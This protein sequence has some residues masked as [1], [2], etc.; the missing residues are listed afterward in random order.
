MCTW[1]APSRAFSSIRI[2]CM[3]HSVIGAR[4]DG[5]F[6]SRRRPSCSQ[7]AARCASTRSTRTPGSAPAEGKR[8]MFGYIPELYAKET[9]DTEEEADRW[10]QESVTGKEST[11]RRT[12]DL[13]P[14]DIT[15]RAIHAEVKAGRG[16]PHGG[17]FLDIATRRSAE[18]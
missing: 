4:T 1:S 17:V 2:A 3:A 15:A 8:F 18:D 12:A 16:S 6:S 9:A 13:L 5:S 11:A 10:L 14:R 7:R